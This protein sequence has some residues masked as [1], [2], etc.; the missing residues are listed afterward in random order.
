MIMKVIVRT[1][2]RTTIAMNI[3]E[4]FTVDGVAAMVRDS[5]GVFVARLGLLEAAKTA[6]FAVAVSGWLVS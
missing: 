6:P 2:R 1:T 5:L 3:V 4:G